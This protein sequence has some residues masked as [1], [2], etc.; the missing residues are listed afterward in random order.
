MAIIAVTIATIAATMTV[1]VYDCL[2]HYHGNYFKW[3]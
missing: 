1:T 3:T 2:D